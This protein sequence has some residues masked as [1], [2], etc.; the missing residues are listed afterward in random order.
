MDE[1]QIIVLALIQGITEFLPVSSSGHLIL[2][3]EV[4][5]WPDQGL[6]F[7]VAVHIGTLAAVL[8]YFRKDVFG[9]AGGWLNHCFRGKVTPESRMAWF[10]ILATIPAVMLGGLMSATGVDE[11]IRSVLV[12]IATTLVFGVLLGVADR[13]GSRAQDMESM[14]WKQALGIGL[15]QAL[16]LIPG[17]SRSGVT[18]TA[19]LLM[20]FTREAAARFSFL[21]SIP[22]IVGAGLLLT[23]KLIEA[24]VDSSQWKE[25]AMGAVVSGI[26]AFICIH[27][28]MG[29]I[30]RIG[31]MPFVVYRILLGFVLL[32]VW[33]Y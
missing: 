5:G 10:I 32:G 27:W 23:L 19:A 28:F 29:F 26:S 22:V 4:L 21:L 33:F 2:P 31:L 11:M 1:I 8:I 24:G 9:L 15:A 13:M 12:I 7:D 20:G 6:A 30:Q 16:A 3:S 18:M 17:T 25:L 14:S